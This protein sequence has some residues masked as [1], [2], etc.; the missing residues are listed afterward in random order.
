MQPLQQLAAATQRLAAGDYDAHVSVHSS[1]ELGR[2]ASD[3]NTMARK[4]KAYKELDV[5]QILAEKHKSEAIIQSIDDGIVVIDADSR[6][7]GMNPTA[8]AAFSTSPAEANGRH[9][10]EVIKNEQMFE[11]IRR[12]I[13]SGESVPLTEDNQSIVALRKD[14]TQRYYEFSITAV[15]PAGESVASVVLL[16]RDITRL[17][18]LDRLKSEFVMT[19]SHEL[20]DAADRPGDEHRAAQ[21]ERGPQAGRERTPTAG[22]RA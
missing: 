2:L 18:E 12:S 1:D 16:L 21:G 7:T 15:K 3:F 10:L 19:A 17:K 9:V 6:V 13:E 11:H 4:L 14:E 20:R 8:A 22:R 5:H